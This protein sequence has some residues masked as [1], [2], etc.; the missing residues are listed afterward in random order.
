MQGL[1]WRGQLV[2]VGRVVSMWSPNGRAAIQGILIFFSQH[3]PSIYLPESFLLG[4]FWP[5]VFPQKQ[6]LKS[7][8]ESYHWQKINP[9]I[10]LDVRCFITMSKCFSLYYSFNRYLILLED[11]EVIVYFWADVTHLR[12]NGK[13]HFFPNT[14]FS[15]NMDNGKHTIFCPYLFK[16]LDVNYWLESSGVGLYNQAE[17]FLDE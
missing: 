11:V 5:G 3:K 17:L 7:S 10:Y 13:D 2:T 16:M 15:A 1:V 4:F 12:G 14:D 6:K 9:G 8:I